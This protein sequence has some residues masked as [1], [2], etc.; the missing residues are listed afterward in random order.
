MNTREALTAKIRRLNEQIDVLQ[1]KVLR[2]KSE[3]ATAIAERDA[4]TLADEAKLASLQA[5]GVVKVED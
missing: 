2:L 3:R 4:L 5:T 1:T